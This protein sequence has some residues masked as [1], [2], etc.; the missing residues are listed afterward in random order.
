M[1]PHGHSRHKLA[2]HSEVHL[3]TRKSPG[4]PIEDAQLAQLGGGWKMGCQ[5]QPQWDIHGI[6]RGYSWDI[7]G[8]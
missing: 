1:I 4:D 8:I 3:S 5:N 7:N 6:V 2:T